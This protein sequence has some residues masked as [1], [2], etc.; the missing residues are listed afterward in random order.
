MPVSAKFLKG[1][2]TLARRSS[3]TE[4]LGQREFGSMIRG[5]CEADARIRNSRL[6]LQRGSTNSLFQDFQ[7]MMRIFTGSMHG[8]NF[9]PSY[10]IFNHRKELTGADRFRN[11]AVHTR[12]QASLLIS[13]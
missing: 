4:N 6:P 11:V 8:T 12:R 13:L 9:V 2:I 10:Q 1:A 5:L 7:E 3:E